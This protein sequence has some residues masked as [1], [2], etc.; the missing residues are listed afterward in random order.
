VVHAIPMGMVAR[1]WVD[2]EGYGYATY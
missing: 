1:L 2:F